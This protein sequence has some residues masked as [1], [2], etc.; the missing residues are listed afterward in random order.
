[1]A[2]TKYGKYII[3]ELKQPKV[4]AEWTPPILAAGKNKGGRVLYLDNDVVKGAFYME[5]VW[6]LP[7]PAGTVPGGE[8]DRRVG[9]EP[10]THDYD[11]VIAFIGTDLDDPYDLG[12]EAELWLG[13]EKHIINKSCLVFI[14]AG[15]R[16]CPLT[17]LRVDRPV[18]HYTTGPSKMYF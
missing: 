9:T 5:C 10:H 1:M 15:L 18:F 16:H 8:A 11:E 7:Q 12:A 4:E 6:V 14:P 13:D 3:S 17:F 2:K